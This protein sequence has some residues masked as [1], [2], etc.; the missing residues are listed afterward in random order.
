MRKSIGYKVFE[1]CN[2]VFML[3]LCS[4]MLYPYLNQLAISFN[5]G[6]DSMRGGITIWPRVFTLANYRTVFANEDFINAA[7]ISVVRVI[8]VTVLAL[9]VI[10]SC[11]YGLTRKN[12]PYRRGI[13]LYFMIPAYI[14]AG[15]IPTYI[16]LRYLHLINNFWVY[17]LPSL[18]TFYNM[19]IIR[20]FLQD[21]PRSIEE[22]AQIDGANDIYIMFKI[23]MPLSLPVMAT[24][25]LWISVG[26][27]NDW[28]TTLM[29]VTDKDLYTLQY[30]MMKLIKES[31]TAQQMALTAAMNGGA[32]MEN[33]VP[34][35]EAV[36]SA[37][38]IVTTLPIIMVYPFLQKYFISGVTLGAVKG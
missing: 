36:K 17:V 9:L 27:W 22:S 16:N 24:V 25:A 8:L 38:L 4:V 19:V 6:M 14:S 34:T 3:L 30:L 35:S 23:I 2:V 7:V 5:D 13:T 21:L 28:T 12:L 32:G 37:T 18:F 31:D 10:Y 11:A 26:A 20:S 29:Y 15:V 33:S 1:V